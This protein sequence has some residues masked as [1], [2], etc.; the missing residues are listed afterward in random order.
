M[1]E[2]EQWG[3]PAVLLVPNAFHRLDAPAWVERFPDIQVRCPKGGR[4]KI[5]DVVRIDGDYGDLDLGESVTLEYLDGIGKS[6]GVMT[7]RSDGGTTLVFNDAVFNMPHGKGIAG[8]IFRYLTQSTGGPRVPRLFKFFA[9]KDRKALADH[10]YRLADTPDLVRI[11]VSHHR[12]IEEDPS[13]TLKSV[14]AALR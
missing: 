11:I 6:E 7:V 4:K 13:G 9:V 8:F 12:T 1:A 3:R 10:L 14:A 5:E 2:I